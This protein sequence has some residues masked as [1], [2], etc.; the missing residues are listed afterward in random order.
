MT[1]SVFVVI[2]QWSVKS[3]WYFSCLKARRFYS[4]P[5]H[6]QGSDARSAAVHKAQGTE[7]QQFWI[8]NRGSGS[9]ARSA[10]RRSRTKEFLNRFE[11]LTA[12]TAAAATREARCGPLEFRQLGVEGAYT[13]LL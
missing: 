10:T 6:N 3:N 7:L 9:G 4:A 12:T 13:P 5:S 11:H 8:P 1:W 2:A